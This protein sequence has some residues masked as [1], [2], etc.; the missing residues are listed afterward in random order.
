MANLVVISSRKQSRNPDLRKGDASE[1]DGAAGAGRTVGVLASSTHH[2]SFSV[3]VTIERKGASASGLT[4]DGR[5]SAA[6][7]L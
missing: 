7:Y 6:S 4:T 3:D 5:D 1:M 2:L